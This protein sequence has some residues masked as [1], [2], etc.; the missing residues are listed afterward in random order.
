MPLG[1]PTKLK[2]KL[3]GSNQLLEYN[4]DVNLLGDNVDTVKKNTE[5]LIDASKEVV[6]V[7]ISSPECRS[8]SGHKNNKQ[9]ENMSQFKYLGRDYQIQKRFR[10][11]LRGV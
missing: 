11:K 10:I 5:T 4:D 1:R 2:L 8:K 6:Y 9:F 3:N 7:A